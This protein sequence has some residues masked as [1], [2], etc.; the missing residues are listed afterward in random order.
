MLFFV[1]IGVVCV[2]S[3]CAWATVVVFGNAAHKALGRAAV[4]VP[5]AVPSR[6]ADAVAD[7]AFNLSHRVP[8]AVAACLVA[9]AAATCGAAALCLGALLCFLR[10]FRA[11][12]DYLKGLLKEGPRARTDEDK[13]RELSD[14]NFHFSLGL[15]WALAAVLNA[16]SLMA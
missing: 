13:E 10:L 4:P 15:L 7:A 2:V 11:Y 14:V 8:V 6:A 1:S 16:P 3:V 5:S 12:E 9:L